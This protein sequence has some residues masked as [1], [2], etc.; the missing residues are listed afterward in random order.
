M[1][2]LILEFI[3]YKMCLRALLC[4]VFIDFHTD[5]SI[6]NLSD[7]SN[8]IKHLTNEAQNDTNRS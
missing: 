2:Y 3:I 1:H 8:S 6:S 5:D 4:V 7:R